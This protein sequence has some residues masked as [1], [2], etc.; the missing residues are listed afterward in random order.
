M[1]GVH[2]LDPSHT[3]FALVVAAL[4]ADVDG[5]SGEGPLGVDVDLAWLAGHQVGE[6]LRFFDDGVVAQ[7]LSQH[8]DQLLEVV[9]PLRHTRS[10]YVGDR[11]ALRHRVP[12]SADVAGW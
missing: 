2:L 7:E 10:R 9:S 3:L 8:P 5:M 6:H 11:S 4:Y 12:R 1:L